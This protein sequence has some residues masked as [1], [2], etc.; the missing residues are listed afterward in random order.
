MLAC[1]TS[2]LVELQHFVAVLYRDYA[3]VKATLT[4]PWSTGPV[5]GHTNRLKLIKRRGM[6][7]YSW[8]SSGNGSSMR[9]HNAEHGTCGRITVM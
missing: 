1:R 9:P 8:T 5:A 2:P 6:A 7:G 3:A 4:L